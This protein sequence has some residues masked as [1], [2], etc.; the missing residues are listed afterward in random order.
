MKKLR[1]IRLVFDLQ[2]RPKVKKTS[3]L[4]SRPILSLLFWGCFLYTFSGFAQEVAKDVNGT[5]QIPNWNFEVWE[6]NDPWGWNS[7]ESST[8]GNAPSAET[9]VRTTYVQEG[10]RPGGIGTKYAGIKVQRSTFNSYR[11]WYPPYTWASKADFGTLTTGKL[12]G[13]PNKDINIKD[14]R[15]CTWTDNGDAAHRVA[16]NG[17]PESLVIWVRSAENGGRKSSIRVVLHDNSKYEDRYGDGDAVGTSIGAARAEFDY[18]GGAWQR[19]V[20]PINYTRPENPSYALVSIHAGPS[21]KTCT[22]EDMAFVDDMR[23]I[24]PHTLKTEEPDVLSI[25]LHRTKPRTAPINVPF[26]ITGTIDHL[27][28][29]PNP[30]FAYLSDA[31]GN[32]T[33]KLEIGNI[34]SE[35]DSIVNALIPWGLEGSTTYRVKVESKNPVA[36]GGSNLQDIEIYYGWDVIAAPATHRGTVSGDSTGFHRENSRLSFTAHA[37]EGNHFTH[38]TRNGEIVSDGDATYTIEFLNEDVE[39]LAHFDT[40]LYSVCIDYAPKIDG[41]SIGGSVEIRGDMPIIVGDSIKYMHGSIVS[42]NTIPEFGY[43]FSGYTHAADGSIFSEELFPSF[44]ILSDKNLIANF[45][46]SSYLLTFATNNPDYGNTTNSGQHKHFTSVSTTATPEPYCDFI[47][48]V[49]NNYGGEILSKERTLNIPEVSESLSYT[50]IFTPQFKQISTSASLENGGMV[51]G[52]SLYNAFLITELAQVEAF[53][54]IGYHFIRWELENGEITENANSN[55]YIIAQN[56]HVKNTAHYIAIFDT[57]R[58]N[59]QGNVHQNGQIRGTGIYKHNEI[60][61]LIAVPDSGS[62]FVRWEQGGIESSTKD[63]LTF[64]AVQDE[65]FDAIFAI[66]EY[67]VSHTIVP[68]PEYGSTDTINGTYPH[69]THLSITASPNKGYEFRQWMENGTTVSTDK[70]YEFDVDRHRNIEAHFSALRKYL[71]LSSEPSTFG[72]TEGAGLCE[73]GE[74]TLA[75]AI[76]N[77]GFHFTHWT[78]N[79]HDTVSIAEDFHFK[80]DQ[81]TSFTAH[82]ARNTYT[83]KLAVNTGEEL[84]KVSL[85]N[86]EN[87]NDCTTDSNYIFEDLVYAEALAHPYYTFSH[88]ESLTAGKISE[89]PNIVFNI[90]RD[91]TIIACFN[92]KSAQISVVINPEE[93]GMIAGAGSH[94]YGTDCMLVAIPKKGYHFVGWTANNIEI[95]TN[96][97]LSVF[98]EKD[99]LFT[100]IFEKNNYTLSLQSN[101]PEAGE[102]TGEGTFKYLRT[103]EVQAK[104]I[105]GYDF[106]AWTQLNEDGINTDTLSHKNKY[107][108]T[109]TDHTLLNAVFSPH[110]FQIDVTSSIEGAGQ[111]EG[112]GDHAYLSDI[113]ISVIANHGYSFT[114]WTN[115]A[116]ETVSDSPILNINITKDSSLVAHF[117]RNTYSLSIFPNPADGGNVKGEGSYLYNEDFTIEAEPNSIYDFA[118]WKNSK[119]EEISKEAIYTM[120]LTQDTIL[121]ANFSL[122]QYT[123]TVKSYPSETGHASIDK[124]S[125]THGDTIEMEAVANHGYVFSHWTFNGNRL[126]NSAIGRIKA[127]NDGELIAYFDSAEYD[128]KLEIYPLDAGTVQGNGQHKYLQNIS[129]SAKAA[130]G[131][132]F[133]AWLNEEP[134]EDIYTNWDQVNIQSY[135]PD[136]TVQNIGNRTIYALF[137]A[138]TYAI[139]TSE[140]QKAYGKTSGGG[141]YPYNE[142][143]TLKA[144]PEYGYK[145]SH[146][147]KKESTEAVESTNE[148]WTFIVKEDADY[149]A[150][151]VLDSFEVKLSQNIEKAGTLKG[152]GRFPYQSTI[153]VEAEANTGYDFS[154][155]TS[156]REIVSNASVLNFKLEGNADL[157]AHFTQKEYTLTALCNIENSGYIL[158]V[159]IYKYGDTA[160][161]EA[162]ATQNYVFSHW[163]VGDV[164]IGDT[165]ILT[166]EMTKDLEIIAHFTLKTH[167]IHLLA[168]PV[169]GGNTEGEGSYI[170]GE[171]I[172]LKATAN[173]NFSFE[174]WAINGKTISTDSVFEYTV[175][176]DKTITAHYREH[177]VYI[178][179]IVNNG[180]AGTTYGSGTYYPKDTAH[181]SAVPNRGYTFVYWTQGV[182]ILSFDSV[183]NIEVVDTREYIAHFTPITC[184]VNLSAYPPNGGQTRGDGTYYYNDSVAIEATALE[185]HAFLQWTLDG[186]VVSDQAKTKILA[187]QNVNLVAQFIR[188][189]FTVDLKAYPAEAGTL[190]GSGTYKIGDTITIEAIPNKE[191]YFDEWVDI[192]MLTVGSSMILKFAIDRDIEY[193]G[194]FTRIPSTDTNNDEA[195]AVYPNPCSHFLKIEGK[196]LHHLE[197]YNLQGLRVMDFELY[198][199]ANE[200]ATQHLAQGV[201]LYRITMK[202]GSIF[203]GKIIKL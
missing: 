81:D 101:I 156:Y 129:I 120:A 26:T 193:I 66:N 125:Y 82:F 41:K 102:I 197:L 190:K 163:T 189:S 167:T 124:S 58:Y 88:W 112:T 77:H 181:L 44:P 159:G 137:K 57:N 49:D 122:K 21:V 140:N 2:L 118:A 151:F 134:N 40:N 94:N 195:V 95:S 10:G 172:N 100:A 51:T 179:A 147:T 200:I 32:F 64:L 123:I 153:T 168:Q 121:Y 65:T 192:D 5:P 48:W 130:S 175:N 150:H 178:S 107:Y 75:K 43:S 199:N 169:E 18:K 117:T 158:G 131:Y 141:L 152:M 24:Y 8:F 7:S 12:F 35:E 39:L 27:N 142:N 119:N 67:N 184:M 79:L 104:P 103:T 86:I 30:I 139:S 180:Q 9:R 70:T 19:L 59:I 74:I 146:W 54:N 196:Q 114:H 73:H 127:E 115:K 191:Y 92:I 97:S 80:I 85:R 106:I 198:E 108:H 36:D 171:K 188:T 170:H 76:P 20:L 164:K 109:I 183:L 165:S 98:V 145:F 182:D 176:G 83:I 55:P 3:L 68:S 91:S 25:G 143:I 162:L 13:Y 42:L 136:Y 69:F 135:E 63:S 161:L 23:F 155:W 78:N 37:K 194:L 89:N 113:Q 105:Y 148:I 187:Q 160:Y 33:N 52:D 174:R 149:V 84:N 110:R 186:E 38:W 177:I 126:E 29:D 6:G 87:E 16:F 203:T 185:G 15:T 72:T 28:I 116:G 56:D 90:T 60:V 53:P 201:Y 31:Q 157:Q 14:S 62:H 133:V 50:A 1:I 17:R 202:S 45:D 47:H 22:L 93:G 34:I 61:N 46:T 11:N 138:N 154:H 128:L 166:V 99:E 144:R 111:I 4:S 71:T 96:D 132:H 173:P